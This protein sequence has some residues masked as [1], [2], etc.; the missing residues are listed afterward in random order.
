[1]ALQAILLY[2]SGDG[3][4]MQIAYD[5]AAMVATEIDMQVPAAAQPCTFRFQ[6][7]SANPLLQV[8]FE[9]TYRAGVSSSYTIN[10]QLAVSLVTN[11]RGHRV[12]SYP[13]LVR[14]GGGLTNQA[15]PA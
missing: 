8:S 4:S 14:W 2:A 11:Q 5:D 3:S 1:M 9:Q 7:D 6:I 13:W 12:V 10:P 15:A